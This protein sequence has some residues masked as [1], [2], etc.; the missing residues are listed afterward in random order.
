MM[1]KNKLCKEKLLLE[2]SISFGG[3]VLKEVSNQVSDSLNSWEGDENTY[4][5]ISNILTIDEIK[6]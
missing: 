1:M 2:M 3:K 6:S 4:F 5:T